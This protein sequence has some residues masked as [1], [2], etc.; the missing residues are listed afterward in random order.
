MTTVKANGIERANDSFGDQAGAILQVSGLGSQ[1][2]PSVISGDEALGSA[3]AGDM[4]TPNTRLQ[5]RFFRSDPIE[6][7]QEGR[8][9][10]REPT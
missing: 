8:C 5:D 9:G 1:T 10:Q 6:Q 7:G 3:P 2:L 4:V